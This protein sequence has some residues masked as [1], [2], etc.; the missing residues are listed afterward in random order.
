MAEDTDAAR[1]GD[2]K[3]GLVTVK[4]DVDT[5]QKIVTVPA[6]APSGGDDAAALTA[7]LASASALG[8]A[9]TGL[10]RTYKVNSEITLPT[11]V[12]LED[13]VLDFTGAATNGTML[14]A[15]GTTGTITTLSANVAEGATSLTTS[16][17]VAYSPGEWV[18]L[19]ST[20]RYTATAAVLKGEW[21]QVKS[22]SGTTV[23]LWSATMD[24]YTTA[25]SV[26][27]T[28]YTLRER[29]TL[30]NVQAFGI[31]GADQ[32]GVVIARAANLRFSGCT[33]T[34]FNTRCFYV[35]RARNVWFD[36]T[37]ASGSL[38]SGL[39]Y[40]IVI[41]SGT[42][43]VWA[44]NCR[45][46]NSKHGFSVGGLNGVCRY[47]H[48][49]KTDL[50]GCQGGVDSHEG[51][52]HFTMDGGVIQ[53]SAD[54]S[55]IDAVSVEARITHINNVTILN[56]SRYGIAL[57]PNSLGKS[58]LKVTNCRVY[59][60]GAGSIGIWV[61]CATG[62]VDEPNTSGITQENV[63]IT[64]DNCAVDGF[65]QQ[66]LVQA[67]AGNVTNVQVT[68]NTLGAQVP[69]AT[70]AIRLRADSGFTIKKGFIFGNTINLGSAGI[71]TFLD[72][73]AAGGIDE[74]VAGP[75]YFAGLA[76]ST[77]YTGTNVGN[78]I[79]R[80]N[81]ILSEEFYLRCVVPGSVS[82]AYYD[83]QGFKYL[84]SRRIQ[85]QRVTHKLSAGTASIRA[86]QGGAGSGATVSVTTTLTNTNLS[87]RPEFSAGT[88]P[89]PFQVQVTAATG[90]TDLEAEYICRWVGGN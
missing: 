36:E 19:S 12:F 77:E 84:Y 82:V 59:K 32:T 87:T 81:P 45:L 51:C 17:A 61:F 46:N 73:A 13:I 78:N 3:A 24:S 75:N 38:A 56:P 10:S 29:I 18:Y 28:R 30:R 58:R 80:L 60:P 57:G 74:I 72:A 21:V 2:V 70:R 20:D 7:A 79:R 88:T 11:G 27:L 83:F 89:I 26:S 33:F 14:R 50:S 34:N 65:D 23:N 39:G 53:G 86:A 44:T 22:V 48:L 54:G 76:G 16:T 49:N 4:A 66:I 62:R 1:I 35:E 55:T 63:E 64:I 9:V 8:Y 40:G 5:R 15:Q 6:P 85:L 71:G 47:I 67:Q 52:E 25:A 42:E 68:D 90:A 41:M 31:E 69:A 37:E 43:H